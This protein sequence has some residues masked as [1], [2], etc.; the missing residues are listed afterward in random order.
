ML[1][2]SFYFYFY[3]FL[4]YQQDRRKLI[5]VNLQAGR[6]GMKSSLIEFWL[7]FFRWELLTLHQF[8]DFSS[9]LIHYEKSCHFTDQKMKDL[10]LS[11]SFTKL[12]C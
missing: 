11:F 6:L 3:S 2:I 5:Y 10:F 8:H 4:F 9:I 12:K 7:G 1:W